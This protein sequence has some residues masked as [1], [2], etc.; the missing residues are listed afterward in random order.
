MQDPDAYSEHPPSPLGHGTYIRLGET[1]R[2]TADLQ[3]STM[4][5]VAVYSDSGSSDADEMPIAWGFLGV[6]GALAPQS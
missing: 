1:D 6:D 3:L 4:P 5:G 2:R